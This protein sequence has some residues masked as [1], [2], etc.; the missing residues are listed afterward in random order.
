MMQMDAFLLLKK[1][2]WEFILIPQL[3]FPTQDFLFTHSVHPSIP[4]V[5]EPTFTH[6]DYSL[7]FKP[8]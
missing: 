4:S 3:D 5:T 7:E 2:C 8:A 1:C 6:S